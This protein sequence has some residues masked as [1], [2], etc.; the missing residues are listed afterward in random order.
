MGATDLGVSPLQAP[1]EAR[2]QITVTRNQNSPLFV[3]TPYSVTIPETEAITTSILSVSVFD[4]DTVVSL[5]SYHL[6]LPG[7]YLEMHEKVKSSEVFAL[8]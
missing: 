8:F 4:A 6:S 2:V 1:E 5:P 3:N 7:E